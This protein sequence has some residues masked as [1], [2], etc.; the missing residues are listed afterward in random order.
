VSDLLA[1]RPVL[2]C[3]VALQFP[4]VN[5]SCCGLLIASC[6]ALPALLPG[7]KLLGAEMFR[8]PGRGGAADDVIFALLCWGRGYDG[9]CFQIA[10]YDE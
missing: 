7:W 3:V 10:V 9:S 5:G 2:Q 4:D 8:V 1:R 6:S